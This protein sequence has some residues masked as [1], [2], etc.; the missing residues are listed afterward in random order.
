M[1][2]VDRGSD[3]GRTLAA[4]GGQLINCLQQQFVYPSLTPEP[5]AGV[6]INTDPETRL[7]EQRP[8]V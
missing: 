3:L 7:L 5:V 2:L 6:L 8:V 1:H 4:L